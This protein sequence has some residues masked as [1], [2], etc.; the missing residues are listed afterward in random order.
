MEPSKATQQKEPTE[1]RVS[2]EER[3]RRRRVTKNKHFFE[4]VDE[5]KEIFEEQNKKLNEFMQLYFLKKKACREFKEHIRFLLEELEDVKSENEFLKM[6]NKELEK[7]VV[8]D[9]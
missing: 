6:T 4:M 3:Q 7:F 2:Q 1:Q 9:D 8:E 5:V